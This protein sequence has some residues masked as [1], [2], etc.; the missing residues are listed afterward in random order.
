MVLWQVISTGDC[1]SAFPL[2][3]SRFGL[4]IVARANRNGVLLGYFF[5]PAHDEL[6]R[7]AVQ[8]RHNCVMSERLPAPVDVPGGQSY[9][10]RAYRSGTMARFPSAGYTPQPGGVLL[11]PLILLGWLLHLILLRRRWTVAV[12]PWHN[13]PGSRY[14]ERAESKAAAAARVAA[15]RND[16]Q[17]GQWT[18]GSGRPLAA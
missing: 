7:L 13:L 1:D 14:R 2:R 6:P 11:W 16:I 17:S 9:V 8:V 4:G 12:A 18:P 10:V 5:G 3:S 15:L